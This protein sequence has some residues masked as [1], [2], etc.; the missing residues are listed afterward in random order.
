M[1][2]RDDLDGFQRLEI[3]NHSS[4]D[5]QDSHLFACARRLDG[6][7]FWKHASVA[8]SILT[9]IISAKLAIILLRCAADQRF[10]EENGG[11]GEEVS[12]R[13]VVGTIEN[14]IV[15]SKEAGCI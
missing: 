11:V 5:T 6:R 2:S 15:V 12:C 7:R 3:P 8:Q 9:E 1:Q 13:C 14:D 10:P 4:Y